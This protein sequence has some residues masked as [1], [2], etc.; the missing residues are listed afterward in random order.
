MNET[1]KID[2]NRGKDAVES[3]KMMLP[4]FVEKIPEMWSENLNV[5]YSPDWT[6]TLNGTKLELNLLKKYILD[7]NFHITE[8]LREL[9]SKTGETDEEMIELIIGCDENR[10]AALNNFIIKIKNKTSDK[11]F[12]SMQFNDAGDWEYK[13][14]GQQ[15]EIKEL[16]KEVDK[17]VKNLWDIRRDLVEELKEKDILESLDPLDRP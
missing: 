1:Y 2:I 15:E 7:T 9:N 13:M 8:I 17:H 16:I 3:A 14:K 6:M 11:N 4:L 10:M 5:E 12:E